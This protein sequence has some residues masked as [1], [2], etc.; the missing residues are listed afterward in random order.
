MRL[1]EKPL[2]KKMKYCAFLRGVNVNGTSM[3]MVE[4]CKL[5]TEVGLT[6][7]SSVLATGNILFSSDE[8]S[9]DLK[10]ILE[11]SLSENFN[12]KAFLFLKTEKELTEIFYKSPF[13]KSDNLHIYIFIGGEKIEKTLLEEFNIASKT[14]NEEGKIIGKTF[15]WQVE[16][17]NTLVSNF[18]KNLGKKSMK[19][20]MTSRNINTLEKI[21]QKF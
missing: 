12:Y 17:G 21:L 15:Y 14:E 3:K 13:S 19:S 11:K 18:G 2:T 8:K 7:V 5:F 4:V 9:S 20:Q 16:K 1:L 10:K 6:E